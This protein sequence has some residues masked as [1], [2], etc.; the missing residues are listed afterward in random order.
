MLRIYHKYILRKIIISFIASI[1]I[2]SIC[3]IS[4]N[5][6][7]IIKNAKI[8]FSPRLFLIA[9]GYL[10]LFILAFSVPLSILISTLLVFGRMSADNEITGFKANGIRII[11]LSLPVIVFSAIISFGMLYINGVVSPHGHYNSNQLAFLSKTINP[12]MLFKPREPI[13]FDNYTILVD[14]IEGNKLYNLTIVEPKNDKTINIKAKWGELV[15]FSDRKIMRLDLY[16]VDISMPSKSGIVRERD[17]LLSI[18][19]NLSN[20]I[21]RLGSEDS[22]DNLTMRELL[23]RREVFLAAKAYSKFSFAV[24]ANESLN[25]SLDNENNDINKRQIFLLKSLRKMEIETKEADR[26]AFRY[27]FEINKR[28]VLSA[29]CFVFTLIAIPLGINT[30]R[31]ERMV[32]IMMGI[33]IGLLY[34][35]TI[36]VIEKYPLLENKRHFFIWL[37]LIIAAITGSLLIFRAGKG[38][39]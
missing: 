35:S 7:R 21:N 26:M 5:L 38:A 27:L 31:R 30:H 9:A 11:Q 14:K 39:R 1:C 12:L 3:L 18:E 36:I 24:K 25:N 29:S 23:L 6:L 37:P 17:H 33:F 22:T 28:V 13:D 4:L 34:Y 8:G 20:L 15:S 10:N 32:N 16:D 2:I 19:F